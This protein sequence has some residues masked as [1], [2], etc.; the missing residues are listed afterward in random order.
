MIHRLAIAISA[1]IA[2]S[3]PWPAVAQTG[4][5]S[6]G[7]ITYCCTDASGKQVCGDVLPRECYGRAYREISQQGRTI[8]RVDAP[9]TP[10]QQ[11]AR[12]AETRKARQAEA[13]RLE[14]NRQD[15]VLLATY[16]SEEEIDLMRDRAIDGAQR[17]IKDAQERLETLAKRQKQLDEEAEFYRKKPMPA[18]LKA[19]ISANQVEMRGLQAEIEGKQKDMAAFK[20]RYGEEKRRF[21]ELTQKDGAPAAASRP[22]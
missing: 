9:L 17:V 19:Q 18:P 7:R 12:E 22:R 8:R 16:S 15:R 10:E 2:A 3:L 4:A 21:R 1:A 6:P 5:S 11:A 14:Q 20:A 13:E